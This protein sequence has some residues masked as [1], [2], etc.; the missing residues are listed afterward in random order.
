M[1][2]RTFT[3]YPLT[4]QRQYILLCPGYEPIR[5]FASFEEAN[6]YRSEYWDSLSQYGDWSVVWTDGS[7]Y[8]IAEAV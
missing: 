4:L 8:E 1:R 5:G 3:L 6:Q 7:N 2:C